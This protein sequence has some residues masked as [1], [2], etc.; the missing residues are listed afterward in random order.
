MVQTSSMALELG[1][2]NY[3]QLGYD[4]MGK[5]LWSKVKK[6]RDQIYE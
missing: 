4:R 5:R 3:V 1:Y 6:Y 2:E